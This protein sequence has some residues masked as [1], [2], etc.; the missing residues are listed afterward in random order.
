[1]A[2]TPTLSN[3]RASDRRVIPAPF[4][5]QAETRPIHFVFQY[6]RHSREPHPVVVAKR[7]GSRINHRG[8]ENHGHYQHASNA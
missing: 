3:A 7:R 8:G 4:S 1:M 5:L 2:N 6:S